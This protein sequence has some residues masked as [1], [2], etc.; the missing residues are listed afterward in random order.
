MTEAGPESILQ[1]IFE[2]YSIQTR[3]SKLLEAVR[4]AAG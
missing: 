1:S 3:R 2:R 4:M